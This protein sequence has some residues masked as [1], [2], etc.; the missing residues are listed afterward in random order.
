ME[1]LIKHGVDIHKEL[2]AGKNKNTPLMV[3]AYSGH[4]DI[5]RLLVRHSAR[6][7]QKGVTLCIIDVLVLVFV[8]I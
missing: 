7:E 5:V 3:A 2:S 4:L 1:C 6:V 8:G